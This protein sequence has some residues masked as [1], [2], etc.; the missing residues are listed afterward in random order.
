MAINTTPTF[1]IR[2]DTSSDNGTTYQGALTTAAADYNGTSANNAL[3]HT[4]GPSGS[5]IR[6]VKFKAIGTNVAS[7]ARIYKNNGSTPT[8]AAN[9]QFQDEATLPATTA[10]NVATT[11]PIYVPL[12]I[13][14]K[15]GERLYVGLATTVAAGWVPIVDA[16]QY[17]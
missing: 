4:A 2:G 7:A 8:V 6:G 11:P 9:N 16:E 12:N 10:T 14:L 1:P 13:K 5:L 3:V 17:E 15:P